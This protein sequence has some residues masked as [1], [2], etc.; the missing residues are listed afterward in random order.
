MTTVPL[1]SPSAVTPPSPP[2]KEWSDPDL[3]LDQW[4][5]YEQ[6]A[7]HFND[8][9]MRFRVQALAGL[10]VV[11]GLATVLG[12]TKGVP[13][14]VLAVFTWVLAV[15]WFGAWILDAGYYSKLLGGAVAELL[16]FERRTWT[17]D[18]EKQHENADKAARVRAEAAARPEIDRL[19]Q[20]AA[21]KVQRKDG[22]SAADEQA[23]EVAKG[24]AQEKALTDIYAAAGLGLSPTIGYRI[25]LSTRVS[26]HAPGW[27]WQVHAFYLV[28]LLGIGAVAGSMTHYAGSASAGTA[29]PVEVA[30]HIKIDGAV[31]I[32]GERTCPECKKPDCAPSK[33]IQKQPK[34]PRTGGKARGTACQCR[35]DAVGLPA[36]PKEAKTTPGGSMNLP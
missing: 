16:D 35:C 19:K 11:G 29:P 18:V 34:A 25:G 32:A 31:A 10:A 21:D 26:S 1:S 6:I 2:K 9:L 28:V 7:M 30:G 12:N 20:R 8:L 33:E 14:P 3:V 27:Q 17:S 22:D 13:T 24:A 23:I 4:N 5:R 36:K 15:F